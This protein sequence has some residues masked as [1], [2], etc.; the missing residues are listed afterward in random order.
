[1]LLSYF[2]FWV[3]GGYVCEPAYFLVG[4]L[5][6]APLVLGALRDGLELGGEVVGE[7]GVVGP[8]PQF[9]VVVHAV[10][11]FSLVAV[12]HQQI[13]VVVGLLGVELHLLGPVQM[14]VRVQFVVQLLFFQR[15]TVDAHLLA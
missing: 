9:F 8:L 1:M 12:L 7:V 4:G 3:R 11:G 2:F 10:D 5:R 6:D 15:L 13:G 14:E